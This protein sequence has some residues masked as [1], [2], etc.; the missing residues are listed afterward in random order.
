MSDMIDR[1]DAIDAMRKYEVDIPMYAPRETD[2]FWDD[3]IDACCDAVEALPSVD[4]DLDGYSKRLWKAAYERGKRD[5]EPVRMKGR[6]IPKEDRAKQEIF[7]CSVCGGWAYSPWIG[8]RKT[9]KPNWC[10]YAY[11]PNCGADMRGEEDV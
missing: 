4:L 11:C 1:Q 8:S 7:I 10:K 9:P 6:W 2:I 5:A 3:A